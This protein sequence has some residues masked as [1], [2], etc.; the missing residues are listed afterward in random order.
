MCYKFNQ[1]PHGLVLRRKPLDSQRERV[2]S[3]PLLGKRADYSR[4]MHTSGR[5]FSL[6]LRRLVTDSNAEVGHHSR[7]LHFAP[8][9]DAAKE[10][11]GYGDHLL[12]ALPGPHYW[13]RRCHHSDGTVPLFCAT[14]EGV[15]WDV[16]DPNE[17]MREYAPPR[18]R[19]ELL[20]AVTK[21]VIAGFAHTL[22]RGRLPG[23]IR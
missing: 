3:A 5:N 19:Q 18:L 13:G 16:L 1:S 14:C 20:E 22:P 4:G 6:P 23:G 15:Q 11:N 2:I 10:L 17:A 12:A 9:P 7:C 21:G 8:N